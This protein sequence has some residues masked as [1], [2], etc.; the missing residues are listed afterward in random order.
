MPPRGITLSQRLFMRRAAV[1]SRRCMNLITNDAAPPLLAAPSFRGWSTVF[2]T[3]DTV[4]PMTMVDENLMSMPRI[5]STVTDLPAELIVRVLE[6]LSG[7]WPTTEWGNV[8]T[9]S[10][11]VALNK[12]EIGCCALMCRYWS[13]VVRRRLFKELCLRTGDDAD[14]QI[15]FV[16]FP[17]APDVST[18]QHILILTLVQKIADPPWAQ[19]I[20]VHKK[21]F[22][23]ISQIKLELQ[24]D[25]GFVDSHQETISPVRS[26][27]PQLP[28]ALPPFTL[29]SLPAALAKFKTSYFAIAG[30]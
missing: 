17:H 1:C 14:N 26:L 5:L 30:T 18:V 9:P 28:R 27:F 6:F 21:V 2:T 19:R 22:P 29:T 10:S 4:S 7:A 11:L 12:H 3:Y 20:F 23:K 15:S 16:T 25:S 8:Y 24:A 13:T